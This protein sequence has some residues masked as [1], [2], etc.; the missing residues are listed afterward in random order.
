MVLHVAHF[1]WNLVPGALLAMFCLHLIP[2]RK[3]ERTSGTFHPIP[4]RDQIPE[5]AGYAHVLRI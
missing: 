1:Q 4:T 3:K 2:K 5:A